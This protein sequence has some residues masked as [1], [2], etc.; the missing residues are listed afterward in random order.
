MK[1]YFD[2]PILHYEFDSKRI[3]Q[4]LC[5]DIASKI[6]ISDLFI[7]GKLGNNNKRLFN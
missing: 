7:I 6:F 4:A 5:K 3:I 2:L 1:I